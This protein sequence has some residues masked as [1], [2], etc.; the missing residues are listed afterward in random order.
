MPSHS[1]NFAS[2]CGGLL[3]I[4]AFA[5]L[6]QEKSKPEISALN[7][8]FRSVPQAS[9]LL[10]L[11]LPWLGLPGPFLGLDLSWASLSQALS[12]H[13]PWLEGLDPCCSVPEPFPVV[14]AS[15]QVWWLSLGWGHC[16][17][18]WQGPLGSSLNPSRCLGELGGGAALELSGPSLFLTLLYFHAFL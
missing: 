13:F 6:R 1:L 15:L 17:V 18:A 5:F 10:P 16:T 3:G 4:L 9:A 8:V 11:G 7:S 14:L 2:A 12:S